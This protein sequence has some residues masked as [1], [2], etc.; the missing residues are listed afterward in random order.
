[1]LLM[2][3]AAEAAVVLDAEVEVTLIV[4]PMDV[5]VEILKGNHQGGRGRNIVVNGV[6]KTD[7]TR[8]FNSDEW[9]CLGPARSFVWQ[10]HE[11]AGR[12]NCDG[13]RG[14]FGNHDA[15]QRNAAAANVESSETGTTGGASALTEATGQNSER[16]L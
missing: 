15:G 13:G 2:V 12:G 10:Q 8:N 14:H 4:A 9:N 3:V 5:V 11:N 7:P 16:G 6:D 1:V